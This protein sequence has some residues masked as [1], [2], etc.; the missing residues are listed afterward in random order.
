M[1]LLLRVEIRDL[2]SFASVCCLRWMGR[3]LEALNVR[4]FVLMD[5]QGSGGRVHVITG[6]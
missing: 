6:D 3:V 1:A 2:E 5:K 4:D